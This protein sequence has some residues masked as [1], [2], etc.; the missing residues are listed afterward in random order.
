MYYIE[1][2]FIKITIYIFKI[3][4]FFIIIIRSKDAILVII[5]K[6]LYIFKYR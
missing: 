6:S 3:N 1:L 2:T 4:L 5:L